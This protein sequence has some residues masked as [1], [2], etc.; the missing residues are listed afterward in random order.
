MRSVG[1]KVLKNK[2]SEYVRL[3]AAGETVLITDRDRVVAE[4]VPPRAD[5]APVL[6][7]AVLAEAVRQGWVTPPLVSGGAP[8]GAPVAR[9]EE[10]LAELRRDRDAR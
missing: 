4:L 1:I 7:D 10:L 5:R 3:A 8:P 6:A 2:L 9:L